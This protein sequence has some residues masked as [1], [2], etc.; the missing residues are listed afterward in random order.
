M[1]AADIIKHHKFPLER[2][3]NNSTT[4]VVFA[5]THGQ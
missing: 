1:V 4:W 2:V 3:I 5:N